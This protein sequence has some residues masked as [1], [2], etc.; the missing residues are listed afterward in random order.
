[1][2]CNNLLLNRLL[3]Y[4]RDG[5]IAYDEK[6]HHGV[7]I[8]RGENSSGKSTITH[9]MFY[10]LGGAFNDWVK[11]AKK[12]SHV[13]AEVVL[14]GAVLTL[15]RDL[16][17]NEEGKA[18]KSEPMYI[19]WGEIKEALESL[20]GE[21]WHK[22]S[23]ITTPNKKS[24]SNVL[25]ENLDIPIVKGEN[26][27][28][29]HQILRLMY[30]DQESPTASLFLYEQFDSSLTRETISDL[31]LGIYNQDLYD[32]KQRKVEAE[33]EF[34]DVKREIKMMK[35]FTVDNIEL[36]PDALKVC[37]EN[38]EKD[39]LRIEEQLISYRTEGHMPRYTQKTKLEFEKQN[40]ISINQREIVNHLDT[41]IKTLQ[42]EI[43]DSVYFIQGLEN[44]L[45][46]IK[47]SISMRT[48]LGNFPLEYCPECLSEIE[49]SC[50]DSVCKLCKKK[51]DNTYGIT[52]ARKIEQELDFQLKE[53]K[54]LLARKQ[55]DLVRLKTK[56]DS[57]K[58][59]LYQLQTKVNQ[60]LKNITS[61]RDER[62]DQLLVDKGFIEG[63][64][65]QYRT[66]L[67]NA[68][69]YQN[70]L[71]KHA[72]LFKELEEL[73]STIKKILCRQ[74][75]L[76]EEINLSIE[77]KGLFLLNDLKRQKEFSE[78]K[79]FNIDYRNNIAF[80]SDKDAKYSASSNFYLKVSARYAIFFASQEI[81]IMRYPRFIFCDN[82]EDKG[83]EKERAQNFQRLI[84]KQA[85]KYDVDSYQIIY[86]TSFIP[87]ELNNTPYCVGDYYTEANPSLKNVN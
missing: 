75:H 81:D 48:F 59:K 84:I 5:K 62:I 18:N 10:V 56:Y 31:L 21:N 40:E 50:D 30:V 42:Y 87:E 33:K 14:N 83:I 39:I 76:K 73:N 46:A 36:S 23:F 53:S 60:L 8:I 43:D 17:F 47:D 64:I 32:K 61:V 85:E 57:E 25:F 69:V 4:T 2:M 13:I 12:C 58:I 66:L 72:V 24:F 15:K 55:D 80:I 74:E 49:P 11:E 70:L 16:N 7:N 44:K 29:M 51:V 82:M 9:F 38:K 54:S 3:I 45:R 35:Q 27:I 41:E 20:V 71:K 79:E 65:L 22:Y 37:I 86:T 26:N 78:A 1:M 67:E 77:K 28:T 6:F 34:E 52:Q 19:F 63:E 68:E